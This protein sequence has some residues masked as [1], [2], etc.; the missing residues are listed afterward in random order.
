MGF[1]NVVL[2]K[3]S[4]NFIGIDASIIE[5]NKVGHKFAITIN[6]DVDGCF[7]SESYLYSNEYDRNHDLKKFI[8]SI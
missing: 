8:E 2:E 6:G 4:R 5:S 7:V 3:E 1:K